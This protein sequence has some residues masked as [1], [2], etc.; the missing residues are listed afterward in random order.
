MTKWLFLLN[1]MQEY[2]GDF[3]TI[4]S[5]R[6]LW[7]FMDLYVYPQD[8]TK[9]ALVCV[10]IGF[11]SYILIHVFAKF[12]NRF[13]TSSIHKPCA[14][15]STKVPSETSSTSTS[16]AGTSN[17]TKLKKINS[18]LL[19]QQHSRSSFVDRYSTS[20]LITN[21]GRQKLS[22]KMPSFAYF[23]KD[24][25]KRSPI[26]N[27]DIRENYEKQTETHFGLSNR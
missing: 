2:F 17:N 7:F 25:N 22:S 18:F 23:N 19:Q 1:S 4:Q 14:S 12:I 15:T 9:S 11:V 21:N 24:L 8:Q 13:V 10:L 5:W 6:S 3:F 26:I 27:V 20:H 16:T